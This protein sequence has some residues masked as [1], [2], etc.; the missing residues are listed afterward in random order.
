VKRVL[1]DE[2]MPRK[3]RRDLPEFYIR[4]AQEQG[5]S[6]YKNGELLKQLMGEFDVLVTIDRN[7]PHQ[8]NLAKFNVGV[9]EI[10]LPDTRLVFLRELIPQIREAIAAVAPGQ[11]I[12]IGP[13]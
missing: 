10:E 7:I 9:V 3:L 2:N 8:Q 13:A 4:T 11:L 5:W 6:S 1:F 12:I